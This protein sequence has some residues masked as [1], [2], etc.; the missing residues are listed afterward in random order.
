MARRMTAE[1]IRFL[2][3]PDPRYAPLATAELSDGRG[4]L[5]PLSM[6]DYWLGFDSKGQGVAFRDNRHVLVCGGTRGGKGVS[7]IVPNLCLWPGSMVVIDP[8]GENAVVTARRRAGG[9][10]YCHGL[11]QRVR[12]LDPMGAVARSGDDFADLKSSYNPLTLIDAD[13][14]ES[15]DIAARVA[16]A[17]IVSEG[18]SD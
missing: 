17:L 11:G 12:I 5:K 6:G 15:I 9:S 2:F 16:D 13:K 14:P 3:D 8:K 18:T 10:V 4:F 1:D 7:F